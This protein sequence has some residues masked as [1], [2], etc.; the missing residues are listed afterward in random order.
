M[1][2][3]IFSLIR[4]SSRRCRISPAQLARKLFVYRVLVPGLFKTVAGVGK[5]TSVGALGATA[6]LGTWNGIA[7]LGAILEFFISA[8]VNREFWKGDRISFF[9][10]NLLTEGAGS[11]AKAFIAAID[12]NPDLVWDEFLNFMQTV[13]E[14]SYAPSTVGEVVK[15]ATKVSRD[16]LPIEALF[17]TAFGA[18]SSLTEKLFNPEE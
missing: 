9:P 2:R 11:A 12:D 6:L 3:W 18:S 14:I 17:L 15:T 5:G 7:G 8:V 13:G 4:L 10:A 16:E 1:R